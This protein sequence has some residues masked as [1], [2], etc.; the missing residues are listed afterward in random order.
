MESS[1]SNTAVI[2]VSAVVGILLY[3]YGAVCLQRI[4][5]NLR[6]MPSWFAWIPI[7]NVYLVCKVCGKGILWTILCFIP[8]V[9]VVIYILLCLKL[10]RACGRSRLYGIL[11]IIPVV[12]L[13]VIYMFAFS[14]KSYVVQ[15]KSDL[16]P[17]P[18]PQA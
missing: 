18:P 8:V 6:V 10:A 13:F 9:N 4:A 14:D 16:P 15:R 2:V 17:G 5:K 1:G 11:L 12:D 7:L 3:I